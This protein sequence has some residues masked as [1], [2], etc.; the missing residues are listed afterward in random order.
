M[1][2]ANIFRTLYPHEIDV[3]VQQVANIGGKVKA[4][5]LLY[6]NAR[7]DMDLLD[8]QF[9]CLGWQREHNFKDGKN[10]CKVSVYDK[11]HSIWVSKEDVGVESNTEETKGEASDAFKRAC[12]NLGIGREL[13]SAPQILVE[14]KDKEYYEDGVT[15]N[16]KPKYRANSWFKF[17][18]SAI[19]YNAERSIIG[20]SI[21]DNNGNI[22]FTLGAQQNATPQQAQAPK[23]KNLNVDILMDAEYLQGLCQWLRS[24]ADGKN[25]RDVIVAYYDCDEETIECIT[26]EYNRLYA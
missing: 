26:K 1:C 25:L 18:V 5:L 4:V 24:K 14:L 21:A 17:R 9:G 19:T 7:V 12:V 16:G 15:K 20:L 8:E 2:N 22:R 10:Y 23:R 3:R 13:Y 11:D 6:K